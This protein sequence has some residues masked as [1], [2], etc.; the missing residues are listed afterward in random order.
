MT[1]GRSDYS[2]TCVT[3]GLA[4]VTD[5]TA[6]TDY[7]GVTAHM[8]I[9]AMLADS[10]DTIATTFLAP[11]PVWGWWAEFYPKPGV[12]LPRL[13]PM[14]LRPWR[15]QARACAGQRRRTKRRRF[16]HALR[17]TA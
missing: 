11:G 13:L 7:I 1:F 2:T 12:M 5:A 15:G 3:V 10:W 9:T 4:I 6:G 16:L 17:R 8:N 14:A